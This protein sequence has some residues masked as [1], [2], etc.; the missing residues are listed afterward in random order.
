MPQQSTTCLFFLHFDLKI[1]LKKEKLAISGNGKGLNQT[2]LRAFGTEQY[3][4]LP[5]LTGKA[6]LTQ[7]YWVV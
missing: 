2:P 5:V 7:I 1:N 3:D 6:V 4:A